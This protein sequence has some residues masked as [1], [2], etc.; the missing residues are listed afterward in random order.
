MHSGDRWL[1]EG[2][3]EVQSQV[4]FSELLK[5]GTGSDC[6]TDDLQMISSEL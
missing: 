3:D 5:R 2:W 1:G 6:P 4:G